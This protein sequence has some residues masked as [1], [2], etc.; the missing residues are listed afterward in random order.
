MKKNSQIAC[1]TIDIEDD[2]FLEG[3]EYFT[4]KL[5][6][7]E[8]IKLG[9]FPEANITIVDDFEGTVVVIGSYDL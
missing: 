4:V 7:S 8:Q 3:S 2:K 5:I 9:R 6:A 1:T